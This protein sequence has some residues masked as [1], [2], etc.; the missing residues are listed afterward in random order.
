MS[1]TINPAEIEVANRRFARNA[2]ATIKAAKTSL[3]DRS[4]LADHAQMLPLRLAPSALEVLCTEL[5]SSDSGEPDP[6]SPSPSSWN[7]RINLPSF[8]LA[9]S[10]LNGVS[11]IIAHFGPDDVTL[12]DKL[13]DKWSSVLDCLLYVLDVFINTREGGAVY[14]NTTSVTLSNAAAMFSMVCFYAP[15]KMK[16]ERAIKATAQLWFHRDPEDK[17]SHPTTRAVKDLCFALKEGYGKLLDFLVDECKGDMDRLVGFAIKRLFVAM[18]RSPII[19]EEVES[20]IE[21]I[22]L[23]SDEKRRKFRVSLL[24]TKGFEMVCDALA[25]FSRIPEPSAPEK[26]DTIAA[27]FSFYYHSMN[28]EI[29]TQWIHEAVSHGFFEAFGNFSPSYAKANEMTVK[30]IN[31][32]FGAFLPSQLIYMSVVSAAAEAMDRDAN[33][34]AKQVVVEGRFRQVWAQF[35]SVLLERVVWKE[36]F[37]VQ[38]NVTALADRV[39]CSVCSK[40]DGNHSFSRCARCKSAIYCS[41][42]CQ[43]YGWN[44][45]HKKE[46][47]FLCEIPEMALTRTKDDVILNALVRD[48]VWRHLPGLEELAKDRYPGTPFEKIGIVIDYSS[49]PPTFA[50]FRLEDDSIPDDASL[51]VTRK[52]TRQEALHSNKTLMLVK[53]RQGSSGYLRSVLAD[54]STRK[55]YPRLSEHN[56]H[57]VQRMVGRNM[58]GESLETQMDGVDMIM[59]V[60]N[61]QDATVALSMPPHPLERLRKRISEAMG[62]G[63]HLAS[64]FTLFEMMFKHMLKV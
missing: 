40:V 52:S 30:N 39:V 27:C 47:K 59:S 34:L 7:Y 13:S 23:L 62:R 9:L 1:F 56:H 5:P 57:K 3:L 64:E 21:I 46:C 16:D 2:V 35:C 41:K 63:E 20:S 32:L 37:E 8:R 24:R 6:A 18:L 14:Q 45:G 15:D 25:R 12:V 19:Y 22:I 29:S 43:V 10:V 17:I 36:I 60:L 26:Q 44:R 48:D 33:A 38:L 51:S 61:L 28:T 50:V 4:V 11:M 49:V 53:T 55:T 42:D 31:D 54:F 58:D